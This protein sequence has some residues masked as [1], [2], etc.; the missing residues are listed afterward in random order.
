[1]PERKRLLGGVILYTA[2]PIGGLLGFLVNLVFTSSISDDAGTNGLSWRLVFLSALL[3]VAI[4]CFIRAKVKEP[5]MFSSGSSSGNIKMLLAHPFLK[6]TLASLVLTITSLITWYENSTRI[7]FLE[8]FKL[9][10]LA[11]CRW[12]ISTF[13][14][15]IF[16]QLASDETGDKVEAKHR[17]RIYT[18]VASVLFYIGGFFGT[19]ANYPLSK[20]FG[21]IAMLRIFLGGSFALLPITFLPIAAMP[22][23]LRLTLLFFLGGFVT[24]IFALFI[25]YLPEQF[26]TYL[27]AT[28]AGFTYNAGRCVT[29]VFPFLVGMLIQ[30]GYNPMKVVVFISIVPFVTFLFLLFPVAMETKDLDLFKNDNTNRNGVEVL[31]DNTI[32]LN[33]VGRI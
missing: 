3:P 24:A 9:T 6:R 8:I 18:S 14:P 33:T 7:S 13:I 26:P 22:V 29:A 2:A 4:T 28:G 23:G 21:R 11:G 1:M 16:I 25:F 17:A 15:I 5:E 30:G 20:R 27:R 19:I 12:C 10:F 32:K 31:A